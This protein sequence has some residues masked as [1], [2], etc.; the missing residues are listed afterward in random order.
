MPEEKENKK[1]KKE[2]NFTKPKINNLRK[3]D[4]RIIG[5]NIL[6]NNGIITAFYILP[7]VNYSTA[8]Q[9]G[10]SSSITKLVNMIANLNTTNPE[11]TFTLERIEK[12]LKVKDVLRN[13]C[14]TIHLYK[15][16]YEMPLEFTKII[17]DDVQEYCL[18]GV[19]IQQSNLT[20]VEDYT[21]TDT[22]K[23]ILKNAANRFAGL[24]N[25]KCDPELILEQ[26]TN[27]YRSLRNSNAVRASR[28]FVFYTYVSKVY[29]SYILSYD[30][31]SY[32]NENT[33]EDIMCAVAQT[34]TDNFGW[35][36]M[37]NEGVEIFGLNA[38][39]TYGCML[40]IMS[41]PPS[42]DSNNFP[43]DYPNVVTTI[44]CLNK[45]KAKLDLKK[46]RASKEYEFNQGAEGDAQTEEMEKV[47]KSI[48][49][50][51]QA[52]EELEDGDILCQFNTSILV[53][54]RTREDLK[55]NVMRVI[56][57]C[58]DRGMLASKSLTQALDFLD[59]YINKKPRQYR[60]MTNIRFPLS[61]QLNH[62]ANVG[63]DDLWVPA[64]G[65][66]L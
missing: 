21:I 10:I 61:F 52:I 2:N 59:V 19:D 37:H 12:K 13:L 51:T 15:E 43:I 65:E 36:E 20:D 1:P 3:N 54:G 42:I 26:E 5:D 29:P 6:Y 38:E 25:L 32:I 35:F 4:I 63:D 48:N 8:S 53:Y 66:D 31:L 33:Y 16:E 7:L 57:S 11:L 50:A 22:I 55:Q 49:I 24:G 14:D 41:F 58:K 46:I 47:G 62:G 23:A 56:T 64:I 34:V 44:Q 28:D 30:K 45:D 40:N 27:I 18:L 39:T 60:H 17:G 9:S